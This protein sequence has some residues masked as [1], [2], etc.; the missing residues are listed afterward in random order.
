MMDKKKYAGAIM[1]TSVK[2][3]VLGIALILLYILMY[4]SY[5][6]SGW[7]PIAYS[8]T[9]GFFTAG[10]I[11]L[12]EG[13]LEVTDERKKLNTKKVKNTRKR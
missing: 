1:R 7:I 6:Y 10:F 11:F 5:E 13:L 3:L 8:L 12:L 2:K 4:M 9:A